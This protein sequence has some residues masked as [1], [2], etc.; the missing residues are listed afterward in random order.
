MTMVLVVRMATIRTTYRRHRHHHHY[1]RF[2]VKPNYHPPLPRMVRAV[3]RSV[4]LM[5]LLTRAPA[6]WVK[7]VTALVM[8]AM[9]QKVAKVAKS[10]ALLT[11]ME[12]EVVEA[13]AAERVY[14]PIQP[15][16]PVAAW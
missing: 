6:V 15:N 8:V 7:V 2:K 3:I 10:P 4:L 9:L 13:E 14:P 1:R 16:T 5:L 11:E 12:E